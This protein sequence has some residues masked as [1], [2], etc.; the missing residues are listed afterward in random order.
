MVF[1]DEIYDRLLLEKLPFIS[2]AALSDRVLCITFNGLSKS[3]IVCG[4][5]S[6]WSILSGPEEKKRV[7]REALMKLASM[8]LCAGALPQLA[9]AAALD[10][11]HSTNDLL[12]PGGRFYEQRE[13]TCSVLSEID[14]ISFVKNHAAFFFV[15]FLENPM[16]RA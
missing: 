9:I 15:V 10:D 14:G 13:A 5:R 4:W 2:T 3:H 1:S 8:R 6:G 11:P 16:E 7:L 12:L